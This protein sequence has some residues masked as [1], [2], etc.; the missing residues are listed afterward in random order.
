M[1]SH[2]NPKLCASRANCK[3]GH[4]MLEHFQFLKENTRATPKMTIP[5]PSVLHFRG[6]RKAVS[7]T[8][9]PDMADFFRDLALAYQKAVRAFAD[10]GCR[11]LQ[12]DETN[13]AYLCD[14]EHAAVARAWR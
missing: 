12:L 1:E 4:P 13:L 8:V 5:S 14:P 6:G 7:E 2:Q 11:Y 10:A 3:P 9:Y